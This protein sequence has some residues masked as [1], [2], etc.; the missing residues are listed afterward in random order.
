MS[1]RI[2]AIVSVDAYNFTPFSVEHYAVM[3]EGYEYLSD[4]D[5]SEDGAPVYMWHPPKI[6]ARRSFCATA[7]DVEAVLREH[8][9]A[10]SLR[11]TTETDFWATFMPKG[12]KVVIEDDFGRHTVKF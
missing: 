10:T 4:C 8:H 6:G 5:C 11:T 7:K 9:R 12:T 1:N 3:E 2:S